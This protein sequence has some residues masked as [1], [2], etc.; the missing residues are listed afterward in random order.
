MI[1]EAS[2]IGAA[3]G[4]SPGWLFRLRWIDSWSC[5]SARAMNNGARVQA[6]GSAAATVIAPGRSPPPNE[7]SERGDIGAGFGRQRAAREILVVAPGSRIVGRE[8]ARRAVAIVHLAQIG[9]AGQDVV[10]RIVGIA[11]E[12]MADAQ[13]RPGIAA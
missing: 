3:A 11:P 12:P 6:R 10:A 1:A 13:L 8:K 7:G 5:R 9:R 2:R 4:A